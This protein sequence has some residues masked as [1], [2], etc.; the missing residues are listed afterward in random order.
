MALADALSGLRVERK[1]LS[2][3]LCLRNEHKRQQSQSELLRGFR[4]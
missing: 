1:P 3:V 2:L 4:V